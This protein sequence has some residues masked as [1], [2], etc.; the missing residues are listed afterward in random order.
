MA[1]KAVNETE[2][3]VAVL[4]NTTDTTEEVKEAFLDTC[5]P[6]IV[7]LNPDG[8]VASDT[9][10]LV[11]CVDSEGLF[12]E[13][14]NTHMEDS[15]LAE[16]QIYR[17]HGSCVPTNW[18][19]FEGWQDRYREWCEENFEDSFDDAED[20]VVPADDGEFNLGN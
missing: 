5:G 13:I 17:T 18:S 11:E 16:M 14:Y 9:L 4:D 20:E 10:S 12:D 6:Y 7:L 8:R 3:T 15:E 1:K 2:A 19:V